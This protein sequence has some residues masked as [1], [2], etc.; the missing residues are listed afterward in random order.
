MPDESKPLLSYQ[1]GG[2]QVTRG[3]FRVL[4]LLIFLHLVM[5]AQTTYAPGVMTWVNQQ[6]ADHQAR[7]AHQKQV[8]Q[9][10]ATTAQWMAFSRPASLVV[11]DEDEKSGAEL[12][13]GSGY[14]AIY[15]SGEPAFLQPYLSTGARARPPASL[16]DYLYSSL[17]TSG[18]PAV[19][20]VH[21]RRV[22]GGPERMVAVLVGGSVQV[23]AMG[24]GSAYRQPSETFGFYVHKTHSFTAQSFAVNAEG[25]STYDVPSADL[26]IG[27]DPSGVETTGNWTASKDRSQ[28]GTLS[29]KPT[30]RLRVFAGQPDPKDESHFTIDYELDGVAGRI[31]GWLR[32]D[33]VVALEPRAGKRVNSV[34]FPFAK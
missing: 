19:V 22:K 31:D 21:G 7:I 3:Q 1:V 25:N 26:S 28:P 4:L 5:T 16:P 15:V 32:A 13:S 2:Q 9:A 18:Q 29:Y 10:Q 34:W 17:R 20:F 6:W 27:D 24:S 8:R 11:W 12:L 33:G 23:T 30:E 14:S